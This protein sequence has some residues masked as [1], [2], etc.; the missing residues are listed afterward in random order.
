[1]VMVKNRVEN[2]ASAGKPNRFMELEGLRVVAAFVVVLY[3]AA[4]IFY[5]GYFYGVGSRYAPIQNMPFEDNLYQNPFSALLSGTFAVGIF[6]VLSGFV[7]SIGF[8]QKKG[9]SQVIKKLASK[10]YLR[11]M[12]PALASVIIAW[13]ILSFGLGALLPATKAITHSGWMDLIWAID[14]NWSSALYQGFVDIFVTGH[15]EYNPVLW[16]IQYEF[17]GSFIIFGSLL[18]FAASRHRW[19]VYACLLFLFSIAWTWLLGFIVGMIFADIYVNKRSWLEKFNNRLAYLL[20]LAG[21]IFG[22]YPSGEVTNP[23]YKFI[24]V[25]GFQFG[26]LI[27]FYITIGAA[28]VVFAVLASSSIKRVLGHRWLSRFGKY[29]YSFYL[30]HMPV[31]FTVCTS[32]FLLAL[33][34]GF[35]KASIVAVAAALVVLVPATY[36]FEK[37]ID[38][39]AIRFAGLCTDVYLGKR[40]LNLKE[41]HAR[42][43]LYIAAKL[44]MLRRRNIAEIMPEIEAE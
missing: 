34:I 24:Q 20:I 2:Q 26:Q 5:P 17:I 33:P 30:I 10:R 4:L 22:S 41:K 15:V 43:R 39:P 12:L 14:P 29:T 3:H 28:L 19:V 16:T 31:L 13:L 11:L 27:A 32:V 7:L 44:S 21:I 9:D 37:F 25:P 6:F 23:F 38:A 36:V 40:Q 35:H 18:M 1:M 42:L 8:F